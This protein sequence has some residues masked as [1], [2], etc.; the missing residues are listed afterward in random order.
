MGGDWTG[1]WSDPAHWADDKGGDTFG[2]P[3]STNATARID[4]G[5]VSMD[6]SATIGWIVFGADGPVTISGPGTLT[7]S[8]DTYSGCWLLVPDGADVVFADGVTA[9][10]PTA[11]LAISAP[12]KAQ[13]NYAARL[14]VARG[15]SLR[16]MDVILDYGGVFEID[17]A[18]GRVDGV[19]LNHGASATGR[20][21]YPATGGLLRLAGAA[22]SLTVTK[23]IRCYNTAGCTVGGAVEF[24]VPKGGWA[25]APIAMTG[26]GAGYTFCGDSNAS[27][28]AVAIPVRVAEDAPVYRIAGTVDTEL[29]T[30][31]VPHTDGAALVSLVPVRQADK[32][33]EHRRLYLASDDLSLR[34]VFR[35]CG[36]VIIVK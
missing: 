29:A 14:A 20:N 35:G 23:N 27:A 11:S 21:A 18:T 26:T 30:W 2:Y 17:N 25:A 33:P 28:N 10:F 22:P 4:Q 12:D 6:V 7:V 16:A 3:R 8:S 1:D 13:T 5:T 19:Y 36:T 31:R 34:L 15:A 24:S 9:N 32:D